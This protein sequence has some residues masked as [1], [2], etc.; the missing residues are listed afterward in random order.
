MAGMSRERQGEIA[1]KVLK[2]M[3]RQRG[4]T[5]SPDKMREFGNLAKETGIPVDEL[6]TFAKPIF[7]EML[8]DCF[9]SK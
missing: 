9:A 8:D 4:V 2:Y 5:L 3:L 6:K 1:L 7:Q